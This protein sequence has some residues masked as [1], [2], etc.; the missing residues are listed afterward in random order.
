MR[1]C[2]PRLRVQDLLKE[3]ALHIESRP[4]VSQIR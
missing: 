3:A 2:K 4:I 1:H